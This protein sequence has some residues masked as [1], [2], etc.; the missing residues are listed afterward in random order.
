L[1]RATM[2][3]ATPDTQESGGAPN[4]S[5]KSFHSDS[6]FRGNP[7]QPTSRVA[8]EKSERNWT[9]EWTRTEANLRGKIIRVPLC[10]FVAKISSYAYHIPRHRH[11]T[12]RPDD[13]L[14]LRGL[15]VV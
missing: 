11:I 8:A 4:Q 5:S 1:L 12:G 10:P 6:L 14:R 7:Q 3:R 9:V 13:C 15:R 2:R